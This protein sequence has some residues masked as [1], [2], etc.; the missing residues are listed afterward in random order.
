M[1][2][3]NVSQEEI[4]TNTDYANKLL[5]VSNDI[6]VFNLLKKAVPI[7]NTRY[8][9]SIF[10]GILKITIFVLYVYVVS[11]VKITIFFFIVSNSFRLT[12]RDIPHLLL[13]LSLSLR[14]FP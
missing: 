14:G 12:N 8:Y 1:K 11:F 9:Q 7:M 4:D 2:D 13:L 5:D 10:E 6:I 3:R